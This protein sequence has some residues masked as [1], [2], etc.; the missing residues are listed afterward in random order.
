M[1][2]IETL[3]K[4]Y[5]DAYHIVQEHKKDKR[6]TTPPNTAYKRYKD[7]EKLV[8]AANNLKAELTKQYESAPTWGLFRAL[9][10]VRWKVY[11]AM[12][13]ANTA[14]TTYNPAAGIISH[15]PLPYPK[16]KMKQGTLPK[17]HEVHA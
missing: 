5:K 2:T 8:T 12:W 6:Y 14:Y 4:Q 10:R 7:A 13:D 9:D 17:P 15:T 16:S 1:L 11:S 3:R